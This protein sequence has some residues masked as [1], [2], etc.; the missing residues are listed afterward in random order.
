MISKL[1]D[2]Q[3][4]RDFSNYYLSLKIFLM[5]I[6]NSNSDLNEKKGNLNPFTGI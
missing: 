6:K 3:K 1:E 5:K 2:L 4:K